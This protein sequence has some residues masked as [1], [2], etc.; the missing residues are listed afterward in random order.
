MSSQDLP[1]PDFVRNMKLIG[2]S[3]Q[4]GR[5]GRRAGDGQQGPRLCRP[6]VLQGLQRDRRARS[7]R[8]QA[9]QVR[10]GA[11]QHL[12]HPSA[13]PRRPAAGDQCA[14]HVRGAGIPGR[15][16]VLHRLAQRSGRRGRGCAGRKARL[17]RGHGGLRH[18]Q[19]G[20][21]APDRLHAGR[22]RRH[23]PHLV[24][25]RPLGLCLGDAR[26]LHRLHLHDRR[27]GRSR[28]SRR[29]PAATGCP[30]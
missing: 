30:A 20:R 26:R 14:R 6:H 10:A 13:D 5:P 29:K 24:H 28:R 27:H 9:G 16:Q 23:S 21:A 1:K 8:A 3:D 15:A 12:D 19:P 4:G 17:D 2:Y 7:A 11:A 22:R 25:R 18:C